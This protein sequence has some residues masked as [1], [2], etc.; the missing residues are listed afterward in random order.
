MGNKKLNDMTT[1]EKLAALQ[2]GASLNNTDAFGAPLPSQSQVPNSYNPGSY[3]TDDDT[4]ARV[5]AAQ[6]SL[7]DPQNQAKYQMQPKAQPQM[8]PQ[9]SDADIAAAASE[10]AQDAGQPQPVPRRF[11]KL[12]G[13]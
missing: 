3:Q 1:E 13:Q 9:P 11:K 12:L 2:A 4:S 5:R 7:L 10:F 6:Q 8:A